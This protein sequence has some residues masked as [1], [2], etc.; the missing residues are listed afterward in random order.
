MADSEQDILFKLKTEA[1]TAGA[2]KVTEAIKD[3]GEEARKVDKESRDAA[4]DERRRGVETEIRQRI[5]ADGW[6]KVAT[7]LG[8]YGALIRNHAKDLDGLSASQQQF[9]SK[10][11]EAL[12]MAGGFGESVAVGFSRGGPIGA[13]VAGAVNAG[14]QIYNAWR[15]T[16]DELEKTKD[17]VKFAAEMQ[18][19]LYDLKAKLPLITMLETANALLDEQYAKFKRNEQVAQADRGTAAAKTSA[20]VAT[21]VAGGKLT[22]TAGSA[23]VAAAQV[24]DEIISVNKE[25]EAAQ[26]EVAA[27][28]GE[29]GKLRA[30]AMRMANGSA[31]QVD[32][33]EKVKEQEKLLND[34]AK[35]VI[36]LQAASAAKMTEITTKGRQEMESASR[37]GLDDVTAAG[38]KFRDE[39]KAGIEAEG[40]KATNEA[41]GIYAIVSKLLADGELTADELGRYNE[42]LVRMNGLQEK[43]LPAIAEAL[44]SAVTTLTSQYEIINPL[45]TEMKRLQGQFEEMRRTSSGFPLPQ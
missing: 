16:N 22:E 7:K 1:E 37:E 21:Q 15:E 31:E 18:Q 2:E 45:V 32:A 20:E 43:N 27:M 23:K 13:V 29:V 4:E 36:A 12:E 11:G 41:K 33:M 24:A 10:T 39:L 26:R 28:S 44:K 6:A 40:A 38:V 5:A 14:T 42:Q 8:E 19:K 3:T 25:V 17:K 34:K 35:D 30:N 9:I